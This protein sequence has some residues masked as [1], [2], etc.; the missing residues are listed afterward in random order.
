MSGLLKLSSIKGVAIY[1]CFP[2]HTSTLPR[3]YVLVIH[4]DS[5]GELIVWGNG[6]TKDIALHYW[7]FI[8]FIKVASALPQVQN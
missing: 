2:T 1:F 6:K 4:S 3:T 8:K 7:L 5:N